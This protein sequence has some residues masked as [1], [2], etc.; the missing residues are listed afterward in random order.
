MFARHPDSLI[1]AT[2]NTW[3]LGAT[4]DYVGRS[5]LDAAFLSRFPIRIHWDYDEKLEQ[6]ICG[7]VQW[8]KRVQKA[9]R[10]AKKAGIKVIICPRISIGGAALINAG[11]DEDKAAKLTYLANLTPEQRQIIEAH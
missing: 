7:N 3:G 10:A 2:A 11:M 1:I 4:A 5:K 9:R 8:A 6:Q